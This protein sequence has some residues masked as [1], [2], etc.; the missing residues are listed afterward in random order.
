MES[1][2]GRG[3]IPSSPEALFRRQVVSMVI[4]WMLSGEPRA[5]AVRRAASMVHP[6]FQGEPRRVSV[7]TVY[8]WLAAYQAEG[9]AGLGSESHERGPSSKVLDDKL[10]RFIAEQKEKDLQASLPELLRRARELGVTDPHERTDRTTVW[11]AC[12]RMGLPVRRRKKQRDRD[13]RRFA[14][15]HRME[16]VLSDGKHFRAGATRARRVALFFLDDSSRYG[17]HVV[18]GTSENQELFLRG[19]YEAIRQVGL[20]SLLYLDHGPGFTALDTMEVVKNLN[21]LLLHGEKQY[22][23]GHGKIERF[24]R[25]A[26]AAVLRGYDGRPD[27][28]PECSALELRLQHYLREVYNHTPHESLGKQT[29]SE[30]FHADTKALRFPKDDNEL[31]RRFMVSIDRRVSNDH[32]VSIDSTLYELPRGYATHLWSVPRTY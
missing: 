1:N 4:A 14:Y 28:D 15:P 23:E 3:D 20:M 9:I 27:V 25:T 31:R 19:L 2:K 7:R 11:R 26:L 18:V 29:P 5:D 30:R 17:L 12:K 10:L 32:V 24:N 6:T 21:V 16:M 13:S 22:P 8:R